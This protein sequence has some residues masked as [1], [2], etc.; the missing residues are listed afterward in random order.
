MYG[1]QELKDA[2][3]AIGATAAVLDSVFADGKVNAADLTKV[4]A[5]FSA[6]QAFGKVDYTKL[7]PEVSDLT[8]AEAKDLS[9]HFQSVFNL[10]NDS[11]EL[12]IETGIDI[13]IAVVDV[14]AMISGIV[15]GSKIS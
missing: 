9:A 11:V 2:A 14:I 4:P 7:I 1:I 15:K 8:A 6:L 10:K 3:S 5:M 13:I 12:T